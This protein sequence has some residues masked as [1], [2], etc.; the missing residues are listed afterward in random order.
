MNTVKPFA[1]FFAAVLLAGAST[2]SADGRTAARPDVPVVLEEV[3]V[4]AKAPN[5]PTTFE[6]IIVVAERLDEPKAASARKAPA[7]VEL[8]VERPTV[9]ITLIS[10]DVVAVRPTLSL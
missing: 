4:T 9:D 8:D 3:V 1:A 5:G 6:E 2:A 7:R 10:T